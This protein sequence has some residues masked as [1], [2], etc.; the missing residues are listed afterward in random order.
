MEHLYKMTWFENG[1]D[2]E[3][4]CD[5]LND[6]SAS[7]RVLLRTTDKSRITGNRF[8]NITLVDANLYHHVGDGF[9]VLK[10]TFKQS[11]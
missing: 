7:I 2:Q 1:K 4:I 9:Y 10:S 11:S 8:G 3:R 6:V 5:S